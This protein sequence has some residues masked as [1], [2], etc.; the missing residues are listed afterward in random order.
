MGQGQGISLLCEVEE[1]VDVMWWKAMSKT[2][3]KNWFGV[4]FPP[5]VGHMA[6]FGEG[7]DFVL[8]VLSH[9]KTPSSLLSLYTHRIAPTHPGENTR[10]SLTRD[11]KMNYLYANWYGTKHFLALFDMTIRDQVLFGAKSIWWKY[12][13]MTNF[14]LVRYGA[15]RYV[16]GSF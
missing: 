9:S 14:S 13:A 2:V 6:Q 16:W 1:C 15:M 5:E 10:G 12:E 3:Q 7:L 8:S 4:H 11:G